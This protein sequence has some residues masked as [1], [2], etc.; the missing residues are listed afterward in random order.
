MLLTNLKLASIVSG[1]DSE[2][3]NNTTATDPSD[4]GRAQIS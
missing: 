1:V 4:K 3:E 2:C